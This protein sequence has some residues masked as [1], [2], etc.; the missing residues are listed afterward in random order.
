MQDMYCRKQPFN[1]H[2]NT[3]SFK[4]GFNIFALRYKS[5]KNAKI[6]F[7]SASVY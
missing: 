5:E 4:T 2:F 6:N 7:G 1:C 3:S